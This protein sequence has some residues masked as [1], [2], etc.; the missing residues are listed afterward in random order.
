MSEQM[1]TALAVSALVVA[2]LGWT[3]IG[4][5]AR[6][7]VFPPNSVG[8]AQLRGNAVTSPKIRNGS[9][10]GIDIQKRAI[11]AVHVK[12]GSLVAA[13]FK[14]GQLPAGP[15]GDKGDKG[16]DGTVAAYTKQTGTG[17][18][19]PLTTAATPLVSLALPAGRYALFGRVQISWDPVDASYF[20]T[21]RVIGG[22]KEDL[23]QV[24]GAGAENGVAS[25]NLLVDLPAAATVSLVCADLAAAESRW[26][27]ARL[28]AVQANRIVEQ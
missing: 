13:S 14:A 10:A 16:A 5:A 27:K 20:G 12:Q 21:C 4:E 17:V 18:L 8:T 28:T 11:T 26:S 9:V 24:S 1:R 19:Q 2:V 22:G 3:P 15:K 7:A 25:M 6:E 23:V